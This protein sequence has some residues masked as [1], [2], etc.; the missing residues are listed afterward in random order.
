MALGTSVRWLLAVVATVAATWLVVL[1]APVVPGCTERYLCRWVGWR[2]SDVGDLARFPREPVSR[3]ERVRAIPRGVRA[4]EP[5]VLRGGEAR[6]LSIVLERTGTL[7]FVVERDGEVV[8]SWFA[9]GYDPTRPV[10]SFSVAKSV[11]SLLLGRL[12]ATSS[13]LLRSPVTDAIPELRAT[14]A[15]YADVTLA[16]LAS[17]R[18]GVRYRDHDLPWGDK[19]L[20]Y[21][22][23]ELRRIALRLPMTGEPGERFVYNTWNTVLLGIALERIAGASIA[24]LTERELWHPLGAEHDASWSLDS[25][26]G[27]MAKME[28]GFNAAAVDFVKL[29][30]L[31]LDGGRVGGDALLPPDYLRRVTT[32]DPALRVGD[33]L[34][35]QLGW[36]LHVGESGEPWAIA[37]WGHLGQFVYAFPRQD[38]VVV[39]FG[40]RTGDVGGFADWGA[41]LRDVAEQVAAAP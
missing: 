14:D 16:H 3:P 24:E 18:S 25:E 33:G 41:L 2:A 40:R 6:P 34:H 37:A 12:A 32:P 29:G 19:P 13:D 8:W 7:A 21:Y 9:D 23:P 5:R 28:S 26:R 10:T 36:W 4:R 39:R 38:V 35:Y 15:R 17:M 20:S 1:V 31:L 22:H 30:R 11:A 27:G